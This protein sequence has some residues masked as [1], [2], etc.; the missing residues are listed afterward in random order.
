MVSVS[1]DVKDWFWSILKINLVL[2]NR[3]ISIILSPPIHYIF[4]LWSLSA[5]LNARSAAWKGHN[6]ISVL[7]KLLNKI[8]I[9][10]TDQ[11]L[12]INWP[13]MVKFLFD[14]TFYKWNHVRTGCPRAK[15]TLYKAK[16]H[17]IWTRKSIQT[18]LKLIWVY[19]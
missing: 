13:K 3:S 17:I 18:L 7:Y 2:L 9:H 19:F 11:F 5:R 8:L 4:T 6:S 12:M 15:M 14:R 1:Q 16:N 10:V